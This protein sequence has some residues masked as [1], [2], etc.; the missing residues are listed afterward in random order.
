L[1]EPGYETDTG[2]LRIGDGA[3]AFVDLPGIGALPD[4]IDA[5][6]IQGTPPGDA[7]F[8]D[9]L[10]DTN[11]VGATDTNLL[12]AAATVAYI[13]GHG[14]AGGNPTMGGDLTGTASAAV[15]AKIGGTVVGDI[16]HSDIADFDAVGAADSAVAALPSLAV[17][18]TYFEATTDGLTPETITIGLKPTLADSLA[19]LPD[20]SNPPA[21]QDAIFPDG[22]NFQ[23]RKLWLR[24]SNQKAQRRLR[25]AIAKASTTPG[26]LLWIGDSIPAGAGTPTNIRQRIP[27]RV[28]DALCT[29][30]GT[31]SA[32]V[33]LPASDEHSRRMV[34]DADR[35][36]DQRA[37]C[38]TRYRGRRRARQRVRS[39][40]S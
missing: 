3:T 2:I 19:V 26:K 4:L 8:A 29:A 7:A 11:A 32:R 31:R 25:A 22:I 12:S 20:F 37:E 28:K 15:V 10:T 9:I 13:A 24:A 5:D 30:S 34:A 40:P 39:R 18:E 27:N 23:S 1:K 35:D 38:R 16:V 14:G 33:R 6:L 21:A 36:M 17:D